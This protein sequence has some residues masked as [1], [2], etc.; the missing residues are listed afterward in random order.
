[1]CVYMQLQHTRPSVIDWR[2]RA[3]AAQG[4]QR[5]ALVLLQHRQRRQ[6]QPQAPGARRGKPPAIR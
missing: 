2:V 1:M 4:A 3:Q 6:P 5:L